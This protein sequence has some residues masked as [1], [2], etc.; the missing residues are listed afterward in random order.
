M[1]PCC[2]TRLIPHTHTPHQHGETWGIRYSQHSGHRCCSHPRRYI[3]ST[4]KDATWCTALGSLWK[5]KTLQTLPHWPNLRATWRRQMCCTSLL[6]CL[7]RMRHNTPVQRKGEE[8]LLG[9]MGCI[10]VRHQGICI[11]N[12]ESF[13]T[14]YHRKSLLRADRGIYV[15]PLWQINNVWGSKL[16]TKGPLSTKSATHATPSTNTGCPP[17]AR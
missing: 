11:S 3:L 5:W 16:V 14:A 9:S 4:E 1:I 17:A 7:Y 8:V 6:P 15:R 2:L 13:C 10:P 12:E